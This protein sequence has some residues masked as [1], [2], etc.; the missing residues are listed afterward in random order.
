MSLG[1][2]K[3]HRL[4]QGIIPS[5][6]ST[7]AKDGTPNITYISQVTYVDAT[8]VAVSCQFFNKTKRNLL[9]NPQAMV[10]LWDPVTFEGYRMEL[11]Y[12][13]SETAGP[14]FDSMATGST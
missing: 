11:R 14:L 9:E 4:F 5:L 8:H 2:E 1:L 3:S 12:V 6:L 7:C 10:E 13:R